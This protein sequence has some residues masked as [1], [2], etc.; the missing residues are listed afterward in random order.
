MTCR[1]KRYSS[2]LPNTKGRHDWTWWQPISQYLR[3]WYA[4]KY[5]NEECI[6]SECSLL[7]FLF[8]KSSSMINFL[9]LVLL[10][11]LILLFLLFIIGSF[12][13]IFTSISTTRV[14]WDEEGWL[15]NED[16]CLDANELSC[17]EE[18]EKLLI[19]KAEKKRK[20]IEE[21]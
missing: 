13:Y 1:R 9:R 11:G 6:N 17:D 19:N 7:S 4:P 15:S 18:D 8:M 21:V 16:L 12:T 5:E 10:S 2:G 14:Y 20:E 3:N